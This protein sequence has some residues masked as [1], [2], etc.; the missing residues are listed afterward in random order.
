MHVC[1]SVFAMVLSYLVD[2]HVYK[3]R[4]T[5]RRVSGCGVIAVFVRS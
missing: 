2:E 4:L 3:F 5:K 1:I